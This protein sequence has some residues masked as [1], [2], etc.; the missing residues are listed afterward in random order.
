MAIFGDSAFGF[1][2]MD[3]ETAIRYKLPLIIVVINNG[4]IYHGLEELGPLDPS[5]YPSFALSPNTSYE[6]LSKLA[7]GSTCGYSVRTPQELDA[8]LEA[9][10]GQKSSLSVINAHIDHRPASEVSTSKQAY[11]NIGPILDGQYYHFGKAL[12]YS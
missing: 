3:V 8:A 1:S 11:S 2:A 6:L 12:V 7:P 10:I 9:A 4:G 5:K